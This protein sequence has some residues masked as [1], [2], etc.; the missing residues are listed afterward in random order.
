M[1][2]SIALLSHPR[3][4]LSLLHVF[5]SAAL[6]FSLEGGKQ[7]SEIWIGIGEGVGSPL[8][9]YIRMDRG[10][11]LGLLPFLCFSLPSLTFPPLP[12]SPHFFFFPIS[13]KIGEEGARGKRI[14]PEAVC[15]GGASTYI[16]TVPLFIASTRLRVVIKH[17][18][19]I[20]G[21]GR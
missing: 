9:I 1:K 14:I 15:G 7:V 8:D 21:C 13:Q 12:L 5:L 17:C 10:W 3:I 19:N 18:K 4:G 16:C 2:R 6:A 20:N 11:G